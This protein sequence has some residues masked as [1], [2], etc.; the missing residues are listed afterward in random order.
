VAFCLALF[1]QL[2]S[3][4]IQFIVILVEFCYNW[5]EINRSIIALPK[6]S[7][8]THQ[9]WH[10]IK[11]SETKTSSLLWE[12]SELRFQSE[13]IKKKNLRKVIYQMISFY[14]STFHVSED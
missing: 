7:F 9:K 5:R 8:F 10:S 2:L 6:A 4:K 11:G 3:K 12:I 1:E 14:T 13:I